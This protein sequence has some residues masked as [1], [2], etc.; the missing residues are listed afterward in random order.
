MRL[1]SRSRENK[2]GP[3]YV[4]P[5]WILGV[6]L[7]PWPVVARA[8]EGLAFDMTY[9]S[10]AGCPSYGAFGEMVAA[11]LAGA[12]LPDSPVRPRVAVALRAAGDAF[13]AHLE[14]LR[15]DGS[16]YVRDLDG[17]SCVELA[18]AMAFVLALG[19]GDRAPDGGKR[20]EPPANLAPVQKT[21]VVEPPVAAR[22]TAP[23]AISPE[24]SARY[25]SL[26][27]GAALGARGGLGPT[28]TSVG[29][30]IAV[31]AVA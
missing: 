15:N 23:P 28:W 8:A 2:I 6:A 3:Q 7:L 20:E 22:E 11:K 25:W 16:K 27:V 1:R 19:L 4:P 10:P 9:E 26:G 12:D 31:L 14:L 13:A 29:G 18:E 17:P 30:G 5:R 21:K 24:P